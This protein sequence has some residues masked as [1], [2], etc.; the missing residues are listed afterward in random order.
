MNYVARYGLEFYPFVK[1]S[2]DIAIETCDYKQIKQRLDFLVNNKGF[3]VL[4]AVLGRK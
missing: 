3:G 2:L 4:R 1:N